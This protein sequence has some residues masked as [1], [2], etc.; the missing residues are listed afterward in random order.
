MN[1]NKLNV[2]SKWNIFSGYE[3]KNYE[4]THNINK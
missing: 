4:G 3:E 2:G 1:F